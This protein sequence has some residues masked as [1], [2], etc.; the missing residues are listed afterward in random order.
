LGNGRKG[1]AEKFGGEGG[2]ERRGVIGEG[3]GRKMEEEEDDPDSVWL[4]LATGS[5][6]Y[7]KRKNN[8]DNL[9][10]LSGQLVSLSIGSVI[11]V[12]A[13]CELRIY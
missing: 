11:V 2:E 1:G 4:K 5:Y 10:N 3:E 9:S 13:S 12:W 7:H 6:E 8:W